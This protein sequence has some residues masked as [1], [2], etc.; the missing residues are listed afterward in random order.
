MKA[1]SFDVTESESA[2]K[3]QRRRD[4]IKNVLIAV[5]VVLVIAL[6]IKVGIS[7]DR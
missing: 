7:A 1:G 4:F 6:A 2:N 5:L 3:K